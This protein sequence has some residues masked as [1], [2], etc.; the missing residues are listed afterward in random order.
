MIPAMRAVMLLAVLLPATTHSVALAGSI[1]GTVIYEGV[2]PERPSQER[3]TDA[4]CQ[5]TPALSDELIVTKGKLK[6]VLVRIKNG[7]MGKHATPTTPVVID[8]KACTYT[9]RVVGLLP[10]QKIVVKNSDGTFHNVNGS[11]AGKPAFNKP[12]PARS[13]DLSLD[14]AARPGDVIEI[15]CN[16]HPWMHSYA[17]VQDHPYFAVTGEDGTFTFKD[18]KPGSYELEAWHP[19][20]GTKTLTVKVGVGAKGDVPARLSFKP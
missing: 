7:T 2:A 4:Y 9:P 5:K 17:V 15:V 3:T 6:D 12:H 18:L 11:I 13:A 14:T 10:G 19:T 20:L 1:Q 8:Q 16:V